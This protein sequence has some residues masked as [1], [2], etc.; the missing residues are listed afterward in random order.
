[1]GRKVETSGLLLR[2]NHI[3]GCVNREA[4][5]LAGNNSYNQI[6][7][8]ELERISNQKAIYQL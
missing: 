7:G 6:S 4:V 1:M 8:T 5:E 2:I 3:N